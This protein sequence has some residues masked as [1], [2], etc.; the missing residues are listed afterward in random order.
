[1]TLHGGDRDPTWSPTAVSR[2]QVQPDDL[3]ADG[4]LATVD[5]NDRDGGVR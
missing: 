2:A 1:V 4:V 3:D 5:P